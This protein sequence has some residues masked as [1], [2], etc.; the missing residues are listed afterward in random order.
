MSNELYHYGVKG[1]K[2][3][4]RRYQNKDGTLTAAGKKRKRS[5]T[6]DERKRAAMR[7][8]S[9]NRRLLSDEDLK[10]KI[11]RIKLEKQ[12]RELTAEE[13]NPGRTAVAKVLSGSGKK[14]LGAVATGA[15]MYG[16][17]AALSKKFD[18]KEAVSYMTPKP[19]W[20]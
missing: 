14:A 1:M 8:D 13:L 4:V 18:M 2:W 20:K 9:K 5:S 19:K 7:R 12:L 10:K 6:A 3:G 11:D 16:V 17:K 15:I